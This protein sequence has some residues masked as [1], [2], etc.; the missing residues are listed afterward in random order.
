MAAGVI[1]CLNVGVTA[2]WH[3][4]VNCLDES[5][6]A[7]SAQGLPTVMIITSSTIKSIVKHAHFKSIG[8]WL[9]FIILVLSPCI[10]MCSRYAKCMNESR[11]H[12]A[13]CPIITGGL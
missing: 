1:L 6:A 10:P 5:L 11:N 4:R 7:V 9:I 8:F 3:F 13:G 2:F 12:K